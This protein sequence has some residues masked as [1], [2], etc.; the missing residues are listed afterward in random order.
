MD[1]TIVLSQTSHQGNIGAAARAMKTMGFSKLSLVEPKSSPDAE[2][3]ARAT[4]AKDLLIDCVKPNLQSALADAELVLGT[5]ARARDLAL[6]VIHPKQL[7]SICKNKKVAVLFGNER[8]GLTNEE[9]KYCNQLVHI[10][11]NADC[12]SLNLAAAVQIITYELSQLPIATSKTA[13]LATSIEMQNFNQH[14]QHVIEKTEFV[15]SKS[16]SR[17]LLKLQCLFQRASPLKTEIAIM[18]GILTSIERHLK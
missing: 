9:L 4:H 14:L 13:D 8:T 18:R 6:P 17:L 3:F 1:I 15:D 12:S 10:P 16:S 7:Q 11:S 5:T 2:A